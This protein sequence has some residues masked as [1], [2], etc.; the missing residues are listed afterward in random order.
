MIARSS[1]TSAVMLRAHRL[2]PFGRLGRIA[3]KQPLRPIDAVAERDQLLH[4][5]V[6]QLT[7]QPARSASWAVLSAAM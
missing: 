2:E 3:L 4:H 5:L 7:R 6:V 1:S